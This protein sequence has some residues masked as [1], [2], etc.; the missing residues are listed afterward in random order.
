MNIKE[1]IEALKSYDKN[2]EVYVC[3]E[4]EGNNGPMSRVELSKVQVPFISEYKT[5]DVA[6]IRWD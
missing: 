3:D 2:L 4:I 1:L 6:L 5:K